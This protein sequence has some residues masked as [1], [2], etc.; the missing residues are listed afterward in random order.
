MAKA[1]LNRQAD[2]QMALSEF[3][4]SPPP[5][6]LKELYSKYKKKDVDADIRKFGGAL[7]DIGSLSDNFVK[8][9]SDL[10]NAIKNRV[11]GRPVS[12][13]AP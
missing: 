2:V 5:E 4:G 12:A 7:G 3:G 6:V 8:A 1:A 11:S 9:A 10:A 13:T